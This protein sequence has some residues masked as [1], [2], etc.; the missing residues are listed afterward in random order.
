MHISCS[1]AC[2]RSGCSGCSD[3]CDSIKDVSFSWTPSLT[4]SL[5]SSS[6]SDAVFGLSSDSLDSIFIPSMGFTTAFAS[7]S[8]S[9]KF[10][11]SPLWLLSFSSSLELPPP[12]W[13]T[14]LVLVFTDMSSE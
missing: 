11:S 3:C 4:T 7:D 12:S 10:S 1:R 14:P 13:S 2:S 8:K 6:F 9:N 5:T